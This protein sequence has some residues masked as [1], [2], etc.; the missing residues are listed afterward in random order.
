MSSVVPKPSK[1]IE[2]SG[3]RLR[4]EGGDVIHHEARRQG[5]H[6][7]QGIQGHRQIA[8]VFVVRAVGMAGGT[9]APAKEEGN[10][11]DTGEATWFRKCGAN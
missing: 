6:R 11:K 3:S 10:D 8:S 2:T 1:T 9:T 5:P 4:V 7:S